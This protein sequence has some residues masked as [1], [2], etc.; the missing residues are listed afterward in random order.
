MPRSE[1]DVTTEH[2]DW[3][4]DW[5]SARRRKLTLGLGTTPA[6]RLR[7]LEEALRIAQASGALDRLRKRRQAEGRR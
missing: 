4:A 6:E 2:D 3:Q 7:W 5:E 1:T